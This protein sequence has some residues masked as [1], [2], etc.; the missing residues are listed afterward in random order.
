MWDLHGLLI[1][2]SKTLN[3]LV[4]AGLEI[5]FGEEW[6][7]WS[8]IAVLVLVGAY[9]RQSSP[10]LQM[11]YCGINHLSSVF[12]SLGCSAAQG[13]GSRIGLRLGLNFYICPTSARYSAVPLLS[14]DG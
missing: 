3:R 9:A 5:L 13:L 6:M 14:Q 2:H 7:V 4:K 8:L 11:G 10:A 1:V 12:L